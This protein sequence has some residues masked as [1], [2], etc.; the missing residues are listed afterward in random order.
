MVDGVLLPEN[1]TRV[2]DPVGHS[3][4]SFMVPEGSGTGH[5]VLVW[6]A[7]QTSSN[8]VG[9]L[10]YAP[11]RIDS[12]DPMELSGSTE[13]RVGFARKPS[14]AASRSWSI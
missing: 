8:A 13:V 1:M 3:N 10:N 4:V 7:N 9:I 2:T 14:L 6:V 11:P 5:R 12:I